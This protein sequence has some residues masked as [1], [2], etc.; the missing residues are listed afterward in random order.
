MLDT[1]AM[2]GRQGLW[3][4]LGGV[5]SGLFVVV[6]YAEN[7]REQIADVVTAALGALADRPPPFRIVLLARAADDWWEELRGERDGVGEVIAGPACDRLALRPL[8][9]GVEERRRSYDIAARHFAAVLDRP[10]AGGPEPDF[11]DRAY[12]R[13]LLLHM[14]A[15]SAVEGVPVKGDQGI[16]GH[17]LDRERRFW[18]ERA[19]AMGLDAAYERAVLQAMAVLTLSGG[20]VNRAEATRLLRGIPLLADAPAVQVD[21]VAQLLHDVYAG[22]Q[23]IDPVLPDLLGEHLVQVAI[24]ADGGALLDIVLGE[25]AS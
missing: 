7:R 19:A 16:L 12:D 25:K 2:P 23:W 3:P 17:A 14:S 22:E 18:R 8:A 4:L 9:A 15:L 1:S 13:A 20:A 10:L 11:V 5:G 21:A 6:D 24:D